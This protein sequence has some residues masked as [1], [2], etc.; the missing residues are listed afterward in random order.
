MAGQLTVDA[1]P[2]AKVMSV[3]ERR[4]SRPKIRPSVAKAGSYSDAAVAMPSRA[5]TIMYVTGWLA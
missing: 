1:K 5:Q 4:A 2:P 3:I